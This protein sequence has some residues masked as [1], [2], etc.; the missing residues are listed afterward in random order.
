MIVVISNRRTKQASIV[1]MDWDAARSIFHGFGFVL[2]NGS[3]ATSLARFASR[4]AL[5]HAL[6]TAKFTLV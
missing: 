6:H 2:N 4:A 1:P 3:R 5:E